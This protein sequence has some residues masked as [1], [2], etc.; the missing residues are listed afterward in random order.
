MK[1]LRNNN[2]G[3]INHMKSAIQFSRISLFIIYFWFGALKIMGLSPA[4][5]LVNNLYD[6]TLKSIIDFNWFFIFFG[7][8]ECV[9]GIFWLIPKWTKLSM[10]IICLHLVLTILPEFMLPKD[11][12]ANLL[13][14]TLIGQYIIKNLVLLACALIIYKYQNE[15][16]NVS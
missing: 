14:P 5:G 8:F 12:W 7:I 1:T 4:E 11:T 9:I 6:L 10:Y 16:R 15:Y 2:F 13:T 3:K